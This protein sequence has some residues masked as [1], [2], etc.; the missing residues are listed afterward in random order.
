MM[1]GLKLVRASAA[2]EASDEFHMARL[3]LLLDA[4]NGARENAVIDGIMK[5]AKLDFFLRYPSA[6]PK[7]LAGQRGIEESRLLEY[8]DQNIESKM[9]RFRYGPWDKRYRKW[10]GLLSARG[11]VKVFL[12]KKTILLTITPLGKEVSERLSQKEEFSEMT[13]RAQLIARK[14]GNKTGNN[15]KNL[16]YQKFPEI[17]SLKW[18]EGITL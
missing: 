13:G 18:G 9:I 4:V 16:I 10:I 15:L 11:L 17:L 12:E 5:L 3:L 7:A 2:A 8:E 1:T 14:L 6:L